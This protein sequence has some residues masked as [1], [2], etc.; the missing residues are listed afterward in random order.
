VSLAAALWALIGCGD[1]GAG[2]P[3]TEVPTITEAVTPAGFELEDVMITSG[4]G[5]THRLTVWVADTVEE[6]GRGLTEVTD[7]GDGEGMLFVFDD[8]SKPGFFMWQ[9]PMPLDIAYFDSDGSF[10]DS[11]SMVPCLDPPRSDCERYP[12]STPALL[13]VELPAGSLDELGIGPGS[14]LTRT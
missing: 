10:V 12:P 7:L 14:T 1:D 9:T 6:R 5:T 11:A 3:S 8:E 2:T 13:A 4:D